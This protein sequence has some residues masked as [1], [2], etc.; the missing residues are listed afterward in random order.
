LAGFNSAADAAPYFD[1]CRTLA[2]VD[3]GVGL[4][5]QEQGLPVVLCHL[6][7]PWTTLWPRLT[8]YD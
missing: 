8:H 4:N 5:N 2:T 7:S 6:T 1:R 3:N